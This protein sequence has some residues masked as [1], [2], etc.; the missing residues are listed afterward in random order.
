MVG[1]KHS[2]SNS[3]VTIYTQI[4]CR[5]IISC[6]LC[7]NNKIVEKT[8]GYTYITYILYN[9]MYYIFIYVYVCIFIYKTLEQKINK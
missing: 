6:I 7:T 9:I 8:I 3:Y 1:S 4:N 2:I 5:W